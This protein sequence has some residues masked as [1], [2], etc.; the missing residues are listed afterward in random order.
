MSEIQCVLT[1]HSRPQ[2][3]QSQHLSSSS[4]DKSNAN[5]GAMHDVAKERRP[6]I[7]PARLLPRYAPVE[8]HAGAM[9]KVKV[10]LEVSVSEKSNEVW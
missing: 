10:D 2:Q 8:S 4:K 9:S 5:A 1:K 7:R 6:E 3:C